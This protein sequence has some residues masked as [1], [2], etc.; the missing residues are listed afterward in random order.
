MPVLINYLYA[1]CGQRLKISFNF[2]GSY[3]FALLEPK[4]IVPNAA[5]RELI[6]SSFSVAFGK[7]LS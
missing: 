3:S 6:I 5:E 4:E 1:I 2:F 7:R